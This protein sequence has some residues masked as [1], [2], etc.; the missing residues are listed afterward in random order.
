MDRRAFLATLTGGLL[1]APLA[2]AAQQAGKVWRIGYL[3]PAPLSFGRPETFERALREQ[4]WVEKRDYVLEARW[5]DYKSERLMEFAAELVRLKVNLIVARGIEAAVAASRA[6][7]DIP[8][9]FADVAD[10]VGAGLVASLARPG[11]NVTGFASRAGEALA[12]QL[13]LLH[14]TLPRLSLVDVL[15][16]GMTQPD[17]AMSKDIQGTGQRLRIALRST[18]VADQ[19][20][21]QRALGALSQSPPGAVLVYADDYA[22]GYL[23]TLGRFAGEKR[24]PMASNT[25]T[26]TWFGGLMSYSRSLPEEWER[27]TEHVIRIRKGARPAD[28]PVQQPTKFELVI[29]RGTAKALGLT[30]PPSLLQQADQ[31]IE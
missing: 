9:V 15:W 29:N 7:R 19:A 30:I 25:V 24:L 28:L 1:A 2:A 31:V 21:L 13:G 12:K 5:A 18:P 6:T 20:G 4:G 27:V 10:P 17:A 22:T 14:E 26:L 11:A 16:V 3:D 23:H 8:I